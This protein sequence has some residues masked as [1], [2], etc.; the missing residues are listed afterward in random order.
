MVRLFTSAATTSRSVNDAPARRLVVGAFVP[1]L[2]VRTARVAVAV[3]EAVGYSS[4]WHIGVHLS[5]TRGVIAASRYADPGTAVVTYTADEFRNTGLF[6]L[7]DLRVDEA[8][9]GQ[10]LCGRFLR[11]LGLD[12][13]G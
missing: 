5:N 2:V 8:R 9:V 13:S 10:R 6:L 1:T 12:V 4:S 11:G 7:E 3:S